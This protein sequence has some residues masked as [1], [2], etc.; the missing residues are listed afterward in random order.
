M[1]DWLGFKK[2]SD[3]S[4]SGS[5][6]L[7]LLVLEG[8]D[9]GQQFTIDASEVAI[10]RG[11]PRS[12]MPGAILLRDP[13]ISGRQAII[14][15][16]DGRTVIE[17]HSGATNPTLVNGE[18]ID[19]QEIGPGDR[20]QMG[21]VLLEVR[22][23]D[24]FALGTL[25]DSSAERTLE[26]ATTP[27]LGNPVG[28]DDTTEVRPPVGAGHY[29]VL[30]QGV[31]GAEGRRFPVEPPQCRIGRGQDAEV[32]LEVRAVSRL[33]AEIAWE[34][35]RMF[36]VHHSSVNQTLLNGTPVSGRAE[37]ASGDEIQLADR[38]RL[39]L[40][41]E[42]AESARR[43]PAPAPAVEPPAPAVS[44]PE[45]TSLQVR[46]EEKILRDKEIE[47]KYAVQGSFLDVDVVGSYMMKSQ[48]NRPE[49][50]IVSFERWRA[51]VGEM[52]DEF[53]G[54]VLNSNG[55]E[56][57]CFFESTPS[58]V[59]AGRAM[60]ERLDAF[61]TEQNMLAKPFRLRIGI[62]T[63]SSLLDRKRGVAYSA[64]LDAAGHLQKD[65]D[66]NGLLISETTYEALPDGTAFEHAGRLERENMAT[67]RWVRA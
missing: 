17:H 6:V 18:I 7:E 2:K 23:R 37:L 8:E 43:P 65:A 4:D 45:K 50:I 15:T 52:I 35:D 9:T 39:R 33:H 57:M 5:L 62:H 11:K 12:G 30:E 14:R 38:V 26:E 41:A 25:L 53:G 47:E 40:E 58:C 56:L 32:Q 51:W 1:P 22:T 48:S 60:L 10:T 20:I 64:V 44:D 55:D 61:N 3:A 16:G 31:E 13:T 59:E 24:G 54:M 67:Y 34:G 66:E 28:G 63:G 27:I 49:H 36:L 21:R 42:G 19:V 46:M 29:L